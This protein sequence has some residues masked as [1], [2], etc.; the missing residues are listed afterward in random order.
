MAPSP[1]SLMDQSLVGADV[2]EVL[3]GATTTVAH[4]ARHWIRKSS[5]FSVAIRK[6]IGPFF[7][8]LWPPL[9]WYEITTCHPQFGCRRFGLRRT[10][11]LPVFI[12]TRRFSVGLPE[13]PLAFRVF[14]CL[15]ASS[16]MT[17]DGDNVLFFFPFSQPGH[18]PYCFVEFVE[19]HS[20]SADAVTLWKT[21]LK[22]LQLWWQ[23][24]LYK[25]KYQKTSLWFT[26]RFPALQK[27]CFCM[28]IKNFLIKYLLACFCIS[29][30]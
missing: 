13:L 14:V 4:T 21:N 19:H 15:V 16:L 7:I 6:R 26:K 12:V 30:Y 17:N 10:F 24:A 29:F 20:A 8:K 25:F 5:S 1:P 11:L 23:R 22:M 9:S 3:I 2:W 18:Q 28:T 27:D